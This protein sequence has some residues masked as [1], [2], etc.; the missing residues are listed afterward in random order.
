MGIP[1]RQWRG[2]AAE[3][4]KGNGVPYSPE[5]EPMNGEVEQQ[6]KAL[7]EV[8]TE[9]EA[10]ASSLSHRLE[11]VKAHPDPDKPGRI[12]E[13]RPLPLA[14]CTLSETL[15]LASRRVDAM[16]QR[17]ADLCAMVRL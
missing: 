15:Q 6:V 12:I 7:H 8:I 14:S 9:L 16:T 17:I 2:S 10:V 13:E 3:A 4:P 11:T 1:V 5:V